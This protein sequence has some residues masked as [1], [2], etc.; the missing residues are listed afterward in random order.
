MTT[1][2]MTCSSPVATSDHYCWRCGT[3]LIVGDGRRTSHF[4]ANSS[5]PVYSLSIVSSIMPSASGDALQAFRF[6][7]VITI[8]APL[9]LAVAGFFALA[10]VSAAVGIPIL[11]V[12]FFYETNEW[13]DQPLY[14]IGL[15]GALGAALG[16]LSD[17]VQQSISPSPLRVVGDRFIIDAPAVVAGCFSAAIAVVLAQVGPVLLARKPRFGDLLDAMVFGVAAGSSFAA[18]ET[19]SRSWTFIASSSLRISDP[20]TLR[21]FAVVIEFGLFKPLIYGAAV[22]LAVAGFAG[23][24]DGPGRFG[25]AHIRAVAESVVMVAT[26]HVGSVAV[27]GLAHGG[28]R[29]VAGLVWST[30]VSVMLTMRLRIVLHSALLEAA[31]NALREA[32]ILESSNRGLGFCPECSAPFVDMANFC[33]ICGTSVRAHSAQC[34]RDITNPDLEVGPTTAL[35]STA[36]RSPGMTNLRTR[37]LTLVLSCAFAVVSSGVVVRFVASTSAKATGLDRTQDVSKNQPTL[38]DD[39]PFIDPTSGPA[40]G[41]T[42]TTLAPTP[43]PLDPVVTTIPTILPTT[44]EADNTGQLPLG[45]GFLVRR[46]D[47]STTM[48]PLPQ[49][50]SDAGAGNARN[51][52]TPT[53]NL[54]VYSSLLDHNAAVEDHRERFL[55]SS[56]TQL[57]TSRLKYVNTSRYSAIAYFTYGGIEISDS[58]S[59]R[60][61]GLAWIGTLT[62]G[63]TWVVDWWSDVDVDDHIVAKYFDLTQSYFERNFVTTTSS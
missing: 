31:T 52:G 6:A 1:G 49:S 39:L 41:P 13:D 30:S 63:T 58:G 59:R 44:P 9:A 55:A 28:V 15:V 62:D 53:M 35:E 8:G 45:E 33:G 48:L 51:D 34:R 61:F 22:G 3:H 29:F 4:A 36:A 32:T 12:I 27:L 60:I 19:L 25:P 57:E 46:P 14:V 47:R 5:E 2:C 56:I 20:D 54:A 42:P 50:W 40:L 38:D 18:G 37:S 11:Y 17:R 23:L 10:L 26:W 43:I 21:W 16:A 24:S 7:L